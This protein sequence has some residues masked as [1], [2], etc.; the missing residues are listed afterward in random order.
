VKRPVIFVHGFSFDAT[1]P[2]EDPRVKL[3][4]PW[5]GYL[6]DWETH[7][8]LYYSA[9]GWKGHVQAFKNGYWNAYAYAYKDLAVRAARDLALVAHKV[10]GCDVVAHS[11]GT[12]VAL[13]A[14]TM[15]TSIKTCILLS[16]SEKVSV[17]R[18]QAI[19]APQT[20]FY[21][22]FTRADFVAGPIARLMNPGVG[23][24]RTIGGNNLR[25]QKNW[26]NIPLDHPRILAW[27]EQKGWIL[28]GD[29]PR[30]I[31][32]H[33]VVHKWAGNWELYR[34][35]LTGQD[36]RPPELR[37]YETHKSEG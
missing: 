35:I 25:D 10:G 16:G 18:Q 15:T 11:L 29:N 37:L 32:D 20:Q 8:F 26:I 5:Q 21:N 23:D 6:A 33:W 34:A 36:V 27:G 12:R 31:A 19:L 30:Q 3:Y 4:P 24:R 2:D 1:D 17:A 14:S 9:P 13:L 28:R 22:A 7:E